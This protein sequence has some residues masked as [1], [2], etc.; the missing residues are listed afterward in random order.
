MIIV[1][2]G[3]AGIHV[4]RAPNYRGVVACIGRGQSMSQ[5]LE[6]CDRRDQFRGTSDG[7]MAAWLRQ[8]LAH[9]LADALRWSIS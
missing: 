7:E 4:R 9:N 2:R 8:I 3:P 5:P 6:A 1:R